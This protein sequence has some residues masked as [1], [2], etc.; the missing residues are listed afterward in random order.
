MTT[1]EQECSLVREYLKVQKM[2]F[3][4]RLEYTIDVER[5]IYGERIP[6]LILQPFVENAIMYSIAKA[7]DREECNIHIRAVREGEDLVFR[8]TDNGFGMTP[9]QIERIFEENSYD[10]SHGYG[11]KNVNFRIK[12]CYGEEY[13][14]FYESEV[15]KG[16]TVTVRVP[17]LTPEEAEKKL[18]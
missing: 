18:Q 17:A 10:V 11:A 8:I 2:R 6:K 1:V 12:L 9:E 14:V 4:R 7:P 13:G 16:T 15:G 5:E 3:S